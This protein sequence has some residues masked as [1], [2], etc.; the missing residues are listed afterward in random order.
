MKNTKELSKLINKKVQVHIG[1]LLVD[2]TITDIKRSYGKTRYL[3]APV[4][5]TG[6]VWTE[7]ILEC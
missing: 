3:V 5:G 6:N 1:G 7:K 4:S 2:V